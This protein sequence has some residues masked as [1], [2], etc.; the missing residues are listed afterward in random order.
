MPAPRKPRI[1]ENRAREKLKYI[2]TSQHVWRLI[3]TS[4]TKKKKNHHGLSLAVYIF[5]PS[6]QQ[7]QVQDVCAFKVSLAYTEFSRTTRVLW[8]DPAAKQ[9]QRKT[10]RTEITTQR[11]Q[12]TTID[13]IHTISLLPKGPFWS[14]K[15]L[16]FPCHLLVVYNWTGFIFKIFCSWAFHLGSQRTLSEVYQ[17]K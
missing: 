5:N 15:D 7:A 4:N 8:W 6:M 3:S 14:Q 12:T 11:Q 1:R 17:E 13:S 9:P 16:A 2:C 10:M